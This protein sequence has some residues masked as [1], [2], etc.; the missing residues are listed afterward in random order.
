[1][2]DIELSEMGT[3]Q[4]RQGVAR[5]RR[6]QRVDGYKR[7]VLRDLDSGLIPCVGVTP[8]NVPEAWITDAIQPQQPA[9]HPPRTL[10]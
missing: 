4:L 2:Q 7:H 3:P 5:K 6:R 10:D 9:P 8:A 1:M